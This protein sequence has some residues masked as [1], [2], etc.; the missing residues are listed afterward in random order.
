MPNFTESLTIR[1]LGDSS[2]LQQELQEVTRHVTDL[3][4]QF[5][6]LGEVNRIIDQSLSR[7]SALSQP[8]QTVSRA[9]TRITSQLRTLSRTPVTLNVSPALNS[10]AVLSAAIGRLAAQIRALPP[11]GA[12]LPGSAIF[13]PRVSLPRFAT[14]GLVNG[15]PGVDQVPALLTTGEFVIREPVVRQLGATFLEA[16]NQNRQPAARPTAS[17]TSAAVEQSTVNHFGG[18]SINVRT[19]NDANNIVRDLRFQGI[20]LRNRRG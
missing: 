20:Q 9:I 3:R 6:R 14:G 10:V 11:I 18:I 19:P 5:S 12:R 2:H 7:I 4:T 17:P 8:L 13:P 1:I 16:L 15:P